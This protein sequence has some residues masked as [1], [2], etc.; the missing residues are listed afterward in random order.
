[1]YLDYPDLT[2]RDEFATILGPLLNHLVK[3]TIDIQEIQELIT[4]TKTE[5]VRQRVVVIRC[6]YEK[7]ELSRSF[8]M[9]AFA[10]DSNLPIGNL[11]RYKFIPYQPVGTCTQHHLQ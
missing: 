4:I 9:D 11:Y 10:A 3:E 7:V 1:M 8:F 5:S 2:T 6:D